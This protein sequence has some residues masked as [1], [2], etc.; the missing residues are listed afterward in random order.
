M[1]N[2]RRPPSRG[3]PRRTSGTRR[4]T[5]RFDQDP[6]GLLVES[7]VGE[8]V[9]LPHVAPLGTLVPEP[10]THAFRLLRARDLVHLYVLAYRCQ[11]LR[12]AGGPVLVPAEDGARLEVRLTFQHLA[13]V[14]TYEITTKTPSADPSLPPGTPEPMGTEVPPAPPIDA[15][16]AEGSRLVFGLLEGEAI[17]FTA[18]GVLAAISRLPLLVAPLATPR[19]E[20][21]LDLLT[22]VGAIGPGVFLAR[23]PE[24][25]LVTRVLRGSPTAPESA[26]PLVA[27]LRL[28]RDSI[29]ARRLLA[30]ESAVDLG[31]IAARSP[32]S[33]LIEA[34]IRPAIRPRRARRRARRPAADVTAIEAPYRLIVSPSHHGGFAHSPEP[35]ASPS[36]DGHVELWHTRLGVRE[37]KDEAWTVHERD[38]PQRAVRAIWARDMDFYGDDP[39]PGNADPFRTSLDPR[40]RRILVRQ[41][42]ESML[43]P[44][45]PVDVH[46]LHLSSLGAWLDLHG[47][48]ETTPYTKTG[49]PAIL[50]WDHVAPMG[51]DQFVRVVYPGYLY[52]FGHR[53]ALVK[54]TERKIKEH[55]RP[56]ARLYQRKF[57]VLGEPVRPYDQTD[58]PFREVRVRPLTTP[59]IRDP[60]T[61]GP[62]LSIIEQDL[63]WPVVGNDKFRFTLD[64]LDHDGRRTRL[65]VPLLFVASHLGADK[66]TRDVIVAEYKK[67][68]AAEAAGQWAAFATS[69]TPGDTSFE[70][71]TYRFGGAPE[72]PTARAVPT[73]ADADIVVPAMRHLA[74]DAP[75]VTVTYS[76]SKTSAFVGEA[77]SFLS[78]VSPTAIRF[79]TGTD[80]A[81]GF[82]K[83]NLP[84][85]QLSRKLGA[86]GP[87]VAAGSGFNPVDLLQ[88]VMPKLFGLFDLADVLQLANLDQL[89]RFVTEALDQVDALAQD[90]ARLAESVHG[91]VDRLTEE[92]AE[93]NAAV[94]AKLDAART[95]LEALRADLDARVG[96]ITTAFQDVFSRTKTPDEVIAAV[97]SAL[98]ALAGI[99]DDVRTAIA[100]A[101]LPPTLKAELERLVAA[102]AP[103]LQAPAELFA[104]VR[105]FLEAVDPEGLS[106]RARYEWKPTMTSWPAGG[107]AVFEP[108]SD[109][110]TLSVEARA[111]AAGAGAA[112]ADVLAE[113]RDFR[114]NLLPGAELMRLDFGRIAFRASTGRK[115]EVDVVFGGIEFLGV[116]GFIDTLRQLI[117]FDGFADPPHLDVTPEGVTAGFDLALPN[118]AVGVFS[119]ENIS[120]GADCRVPF[121]GDA[122]TVGF[123]FCTRDKPFRMTVMAIGG[124]GFVAVRL[125]PEGMVVLEMALEAGASLSLDF[126]VASGSVS[127]MVGLYLR[128]EADKGSLTGYFRIR[129]EVDVLGLISASITL[130]LSLAYEFE[131]G[132]MVGRASIVVEVEVL[133]FSTSVRISVERRLAGSKGDPTFE[134]IMGVTGGTSPAWDAYCLAFAGED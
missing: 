25:R 38:D 121:L 5:L 6:R 72:T 40:D 12:R 20:R 61:L 104:A 62:P 111:S 110:F 80:R 127:V 129:G 93:A 1:G 112:G 106:V 117:P 15:R 122:V 47:E 71:R 134:Q 94:K 87:L 42:A 58:L 60:L 28:G 77:E 69:T 90:L 74:P 17:P 128:L 103:L 133:F 55:S 4:R 36:D 33:F 132:K 66:A 83:P 92:A 108:S 82:V 63:F 49:A 34:G 96:A 75:A 27:A 84:V 46:R 26:S 13:E 54:V 51:R 8:L 131:S 41:T 67:D 44:P 57:I 102:V 105:N 95:A 3:D 78:V 18:A 123:N 89:P 32:F 109:G 65:H 126:G 11:L 118:V 53:A 124:G 130:E 81:G 7:E 21:R 10:P 19:Q 70:V 79:D 120:L 101:P 39:P 64:C 22:N 9:A 16:T 14:A 59:D 35:V 43:A 37:E 125:S 85:T 45:E 30:T 23:G 115:P 116:L 97:E 113:L 48:W 99:V 52:P 29:N 24:G 88:G 86:V 114:L 100:A 107:A 56:Q 73:L 68:N 2:D 50:S 119:L 76:G 31:N 98:T 91:A